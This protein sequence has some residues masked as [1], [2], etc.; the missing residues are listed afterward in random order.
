MASPTRT[1]ASVSRAG[2]S[3]PKSPRAKLVAEP[4]F[5]ELGARRRVNAADQR[6]HHPRGRSP[7]IASMTPSSGPPRGGRTSQ[8]TWRPAMPYRLSVARPAAGP[9]DAQAEGTANPARSRPAPTRQRPW[10]IQSAAAD[11]G[12]TPRRRR[13]RRHPSAH[14]PVAPSGP[15]CQNPSHPSDAGRAP[16]RPPLSIGC[17]LTVGRVVTPRLPR[18]SRSL[19]GGHGRC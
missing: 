11:R 14:S 5:A 18:G 8:R 10:P 4:E 2:G 13:G 6:R 9:R 19:L 3:S 12:D 17:Y 16:V 15:A 7:A 1:T